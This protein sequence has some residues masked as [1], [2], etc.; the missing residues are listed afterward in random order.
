MSRL[1][2]SPVENGESNGEEN[3]NWDYIWDYR[4]L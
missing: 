2:V 1:L 4:V 3:G